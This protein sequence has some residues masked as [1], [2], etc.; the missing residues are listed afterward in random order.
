VR[1]CYSGRASV[2]DERRCRVCGCDHFTP[3]ETESGPCGWA[4]ATLCT[5]CEGRPAELYDL[6]VEL[7][8]YSRAAVERV[9]VYAFHGETLRAVRRLGRLADKARKALAPPKRRMG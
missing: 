7:E 6:V 1:D 8:A 4:D 9:S 2:E 3:C 5:A